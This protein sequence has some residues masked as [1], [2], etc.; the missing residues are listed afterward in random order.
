MDFRK[1]ID[2]L[3]DL[4]YGRR[5]DAGFRLVIILLTSGVLYLYTRLP[6]AAL[7][8]LGWVLAHL[9]NFLILRSRPQNATR[10][11]ILLSGLG[12]ILLLS[13]FMWMP[14][15]L[16]VEQ[17]PALRIGGAAAI[18][19]I[20]VFLIHRS[21]R[22]LAIMLGE[23]VVVGLTFLWIIVQTAAQTPNP[24]AK[25]GV[26]TAALG[27]AVYFVVVM[28]THR[29]ISLETEQAAERSVQAQKMEAIGQL[30]GGVAHNFNNIL[31]AVIGNLDLYEVL[32]QQAERDA[33]VS[34]ARAAAHRAADLVRQL[35]SY[36]RRSPMQVAAHDVGA[37]ILQ[38]QM[39]TR[40]LLPAPIAQSF[41]PPPDP[42]I[43]TL[44][45]NQFITALVNLVVNARDAMPEGGELSVGARPLHLAAPQPQPDG[46]VLPAGDYAEVTVADT[47]SGIPPELMGR[48]TEP[49][50][51]TKAVG[52]GSGLGLSM[53]EGFARQSGGALVIDSGPSGTA[54]HLLLPLARPQ[55]RQ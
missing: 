20:L 52:Q 4:E 53:V 28:L 9:L 44:D 1:E 29:R 42:L 49:F 47:G 23:F 55:A 31:T 37:L 30:A 22:V 54:M 2:R 39:L 45:Q 48:V 3:Y 50:F 34:E 24:L 46:T 32:E 14:A 43:V 36:A 35:L 33:C 10:R 8:P 38:L 40:R 41:T 15:R 12:F 17:D 7:W 13:A 25:L 18:G 27:L 11:D 6:E 19:A 5:V 51:T 21:D 16:I 26:A